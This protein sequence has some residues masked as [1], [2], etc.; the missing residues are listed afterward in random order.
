MGVAGRTVKVLRQQGRGQSATRGTMLLASAGMAARAAAAAAAGHADASA[1]LLL[2]SLAVPVQA[3]NGSTTSKGTR[4]LLRPW[5]ADGDHF[6]GM[7]LRHSHY[8]TAS[9]SR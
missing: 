8:P 1:A 4:A 6:L 3:D 5:R 2:P 9:V 7:V